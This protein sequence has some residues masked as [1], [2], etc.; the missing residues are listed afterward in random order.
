MKSS[1]EQHRSRELCVIRFEV[2]IFL[3]EIIK[4]L[5]VIEHG[6]KRKEMGGYDPMISYQIYS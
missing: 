1:E 5:R 2:M 6:N 4:L 3:E